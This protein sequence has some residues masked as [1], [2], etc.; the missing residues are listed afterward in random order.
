MEQ[1]YRL[2]LWVRNILIVVYILIVL[3]IIP[4]TFL[5]LET[6]DSFG[7]YVLI[8][9]MAANMIFYILSK[10]DVEPTN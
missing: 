7:Y 3:K 9:V 1:A 6:K 4:L 8:P 10:R 2:S 5:N